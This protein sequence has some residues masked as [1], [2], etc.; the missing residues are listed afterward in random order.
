M[1][2][3]KQAVLLAIL[4]VIL[5]STVATAFKKSLM[6]LSPFDLL[7]LSS[8]WSVVL[9]FI[10]VIVQYRGFSGFILTRKT[11]R[12]YL[13]GGLLNPGSYYLVLFASYDLLPAQIAQPLNYTWP[14]MLVLLSVPILKKRPTKQDA[15]SLAICLAGLVLISQG[16][17]RFQMGALSLKGIF[18]ALLSAVIWAVYWLA[19]QRHSGSESSSLFW[20]FFL[21]IPLLVLLKPMISPGFPPLNSSVLLWTAWVGLFEMG[22]TFVIWGLALAKADQPARISHLVYLSPFLSLLWISLILKETIAL[23][24]VAGLFIIII[25][26]FVKEIRSVKN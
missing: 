19:G 24:T 2:N 15:I 10:V 7:L 5:W 11:F 25:G 26:I 22:I 23:T 16:G 3:N 8:I 21:V 12:I 6:L 9:L 1:K 20:N 18:L 17:N 13:L 14:L 4:A